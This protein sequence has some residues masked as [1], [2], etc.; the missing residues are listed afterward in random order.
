MAKKENEDKTLVLES[1]RNIERKDIKKK[2]AEMT[3]RIEVQDTDTS[4]MI[5]EKM[6]NEIESYL[7]VIG[8]RIDCIKIVEGMQQEIR[9]LQP[10]IS[11]EKTDSFFYENDI[12]RAIRS[13]GTEIL[14]IASGFIRIKINGEEYN[15]ITKEKAIEKFALTDKKL[16]DLEKEG[17]LVWKNNNWFEVIYLKEGMN[18]WGAIDNTVKYNYDAAIEVFNDCYNRKDLNI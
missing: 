4:D 13:D 1:P 6:F 16:E 5:V 9:I 2:Y 18:D 8:I 7:D 3:F 14:L 11:D 15:N 17:V 10:K 12:A